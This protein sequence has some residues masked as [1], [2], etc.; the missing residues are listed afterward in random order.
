MWLSLLF[1]LKKCLVQEYS[2]LCSKLINILRCFCSYCLLEMVIFHTE[3]QD[4]EV[5]LPMTLRGL[6]STFGKLV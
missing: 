4:L 6:D 3:E 1:P 5:N 2:D